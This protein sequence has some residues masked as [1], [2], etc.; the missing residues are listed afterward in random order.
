[1]GQRQQLDGRVPA[2]RAHEGQRLAVG[3]DAGRVGDAVQVGPLL[4]VVAVVV[5][6]P[7]FLAAAA[8]A[9][10]GDFAGGD[11]GPEAER[12]DDV[13]GQLVGDAARAG[14]GRRI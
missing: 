5:H 8:V 14:V 1:G 10:E 13:V 11:A 9:D 6:R 3:R 7:D 12:R 2:G 4:L